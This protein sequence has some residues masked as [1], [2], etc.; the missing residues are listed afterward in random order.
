M[1]NSYFFL[2][3][4]NNWQ[5][6]KLNRDQSKGEENGPVIIKQYLRFMLFNLINCILN[7]VCC[8][9]INIF[10]Q[11]AKSSFLTISDKHFLSLDVADLFERHRYLSYPLCSQ[12]Q[13]LE[14]ERP[15][16]TA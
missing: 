15:H 7:P 13:C 8:I 5:V 11:G 12:C 16:D 2:I 3:I 4:Y 10:I 9:L 14:N 6:Q 1:K